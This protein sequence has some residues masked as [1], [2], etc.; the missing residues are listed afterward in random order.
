MWRLQSHAVAKRLQLWVFLLVLLLC[1]K[2][3]HAADDTG[4]LQVTVDGEGIA[5][6]AGTLDLPAGPA[7]VH[8]ILTDYA[9]WPALWSGGMAVV[10]IRQAP[11]GVI[12]ELLLPRMWMPGTLRL[13]I[14][15]HAP[16]PSP[17]EARLVSGDFDRFWRVWELTPT[18]EGRRTR[19][20]IEMEVR[21]T[22]WVPNWIF[23]YLVRQQLQ[24][25]FERL[26][27]AVGQGP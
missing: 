9:H 4:A 22:S 26:R 13:V 5:H 27:L 7:K 16:T 24:D 15:T 21:P 23:S 18:Q 25:H 11:E 10:A 6:V 17:I 2:R 20:Y 14:M 12:V 1:V 8:E 3:L 19:A